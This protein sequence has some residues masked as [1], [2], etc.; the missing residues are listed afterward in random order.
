MVLYEFFEGERDSHVF[1]VV[2]N[3]REA[4][5]TTLRLSPD[6]MLPD[7]P[8]PVV[9]GLDAARLLKTM[10]PKVPL[11][12]YSATP[13][14]VS[15]QIAKSIGISEVMSKLD[16]VSVLIDNARGLVRSKNRSLAPA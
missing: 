8:K 6:L 12:M 11:V 13:A 5:E 15:E 7:L 4:I 3:G 1:V 9:D 2:Q 14:K 10:M 16:R